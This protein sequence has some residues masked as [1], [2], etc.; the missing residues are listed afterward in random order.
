MGIIFIRETLNEFICTC[1][2]TCFHTFF[3]GRLF[4][5]PA[6][7]IQNTSGKQYIFLQYYGHL[8]TQGLQI[9]A[10]DILTADIDRTLIYIIQTADEV[11]Q[12]G[13]GTTG[14]TQNTDGLSGFDLKV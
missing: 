9:I 5:S 2:P 3:I 6:Q 10:S 11:H 8:I 1:K 12:T 13:L 4:V 14:T 7:V